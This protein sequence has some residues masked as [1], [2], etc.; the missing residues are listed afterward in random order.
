MQHCEV[1]PQTFRCFMVRELKKSTPTAFV[2]DVNGFELT[3]KL[4]YFALM[5]G[6][7][8]F[9]E[10]IVVNSKKN[11]L[12]DTYFGGSNKSVKK[13]ELLECFEDQNWG[14]DDDA[15]GDAVKIALLYFI[16]IYILSGEKNNVVIPRLHFDLVESRRYVDYTWGKE[17]FD[18]LVR[19]K[20]GDRI[21]RKFNWK[22][23]DGTPHFKDLM[24]GMFNDDESED[25]LT[26]RNIV[27]TISEIEELRLRP[28]LS[29]NSASTGQQQVADDYDDFSSTPPHVSAAKQPQ[30]KGVSESPPHKKPRQM[31]MVPS[32]L[33]KTTSPITHIGSHPSGGRLTRR[34]GLASTGHA[35]AV[36]KESAPIPNPPSAVPVDI[37]STSKSE[38]ISGLR[39]EL[40]EFKYKVYA[41][42]KDLHK[43]INENFAKVFEY[44]KVN[45]T[46]KKSADEY[47]P[48]DA[49]VQMQTDTG[50]AASTE[51]VGMQQFDVPDIGMDR[52][53]ESGETLKESTEELQEGGDNFGE[54]K[55]ST[56]CIDQIHL[57]EYIVEFP[58]DTVSVK[59]PVLSANSAD[60]AEVLADIS[61]TGWSSGPSHDKSAVLQ[62]DRSIFETPPKVGENVIPLSQFLLP[63]EL[64]P[65]Q[66]PERR[67]V[68]HPSVARNRRP[69]GSKHITVLIFK[70]K[71]PFADPITGPV[72]I[73]LF[74]KY[75]EWIRKGLLVRHEN[76]KNNED[77]YRKKMAALENDA[78]Y[79]YNFGIT[80][81]ENKNWFYQLSMSGQMWN[82]EHVDV[83]F[84]YLR[85]KG[86]Y[87]RRSTFKYTT[88]DCLFM[89]KV[90]QTY[91]AYNNPETGP[92]VANEEDDICQYVKGY[93]LHANVSWHSID[94][95]FI[96]VNIKEDNH[97]ILV[98][99]SF[100]DRDCGVYVAAFAEYL[101]TGEGIPAQIDATM[102]RN[103]YIALL[104]DYAAR[105][106]DEHA[107][108]D[109]EAP[110]KPVRPA[111]DYGKADK[112]D[113]T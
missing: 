40:N 25:R 42:F 82:D 94:N 36:E 51:G 19:I 53:N 59:S 70:K 46:T 103:R 52:R 43:T 85:K 15:G 32:P 17:A 8:C 93:R 7:K 73:E 90:D 11:R 76:K 64:L 9:G 109:I 101:S 44:T 5:T 12:L 3:F 39:E 54:Q 57:T 83:I 71:H 61:R 87:D 38:D 105:K 112:I 20:N 113:V 95:I 55:E 62:E 29:D 69:T 23:I 78:N 92:N 100:N 34:H 91:L 14:V 41:E 107:M 16:H 88:V 66:T 4:L 68:L 50:H 26:Y 56:I 98:V 13:G 1:H 37:L 65:S 104:W 22:T 79:T 63:D 2:I 31:P 18:D 27:P 72:D 35:S 75:L 97:W 111:V 6:L 60:I 30:N 99:L 74:D 48:R 33:K 102:L 49:G 58:E 24:T 77:R 45:Q 80:V 10:E 110:P 84:Y 108:S 67:M 28:Y 86:K 106:I 96:P 21:P 81:V 47:I 89:R